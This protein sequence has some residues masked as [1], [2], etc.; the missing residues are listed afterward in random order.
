MEGVCG[1]PGGR[2]YQRQPFSVYLI[3]GNEVSHFYNTSFDTL[4]FIA[5]A[6]QKEEQ[7]KV[8]HGVY[9]SFG[10]PHAYR[11]DNDGIKT[12]LLHRMM[13]SLVAG[14]SPAILR[15]GGGG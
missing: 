14:Y 9:G 13:D 3:D 8:Y 11:F 2:V 12:R 5:S 15:Q 7:E 1:I 4:E 10:L 6:G